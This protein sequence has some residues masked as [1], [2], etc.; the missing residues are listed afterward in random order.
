MS[1]KSTLSRLPAAALTLIAL[2][3]LLA[4]D[5]RAAKEQ[6]PGGAATAIARIDGEDVPK[7][8][9]DEAIKGNR[10]FFDLTQDSVRRKLGGRPWTEY[11]FK[12]EIVKVRAFAMRHAA[13]LERME[14]ALAEARARLDAGEDFAKVAGELSQDKV[15]AAQGGSLG[16]PKGFFDLVHPFN[17]VALS[18]KEG[19]VS[20]PVM[21][22]FGLHII[23]VEKIIPPM[24][25]KPKQVEARHILIPFPGN[26]RQEAE[27]ALAQ[28]K[29]EILQAKPYCKDL[30]AF[31]GEG[32]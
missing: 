19:E 4:P 16:E 32:E 14:K 29:V 21:T 10:R 24:E 15:S 5:A 8:D 30:P 26:P 1:R 23:K 28:A 20:G 31:C 18:M 25:G 27:E 3:G 17:R 11:V 22:I 7:A 6:G 9:Y 12:E 13:D 2:P